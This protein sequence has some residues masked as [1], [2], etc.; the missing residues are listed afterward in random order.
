MRCRSAASRGCRALRGQEALALLACVRALADVDEESLDVE[1]PAVVVAHGDGLVSDPD[2]APVAREHPVL[3]AQRRRGGGSLGD[4][5]GH[6]VAVLGVDELEEEVG[7]GEPFAGRVAE[8]R[9]D[10]RTDVERLAALAERVDVRDGG[11][12]VGQGAVLG[13][14][15]APPGV[16][17]PRLADIRGDQDRS[18]RLAVLVP[19]G[20]DGERDGDLLAALAP[21][22]RRRDVEPLR[23]VDGHEGGRDDVLSAEDR[24]LAADRLVGA[25]AVD[26]LGAPAPADDRP[27]CVDCDDRLRAGFPHGGELP[28]EVRPG[29]RRLASS[30]RQPAGEST[31]R[32]PRG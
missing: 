6:P 15:L 5:V 22:R 13:L 20:R 16:D 23:R 7:L 26:L 29:P 31:D 27:L 24:K 1:R 8:Q 32:E 12:V 9:R 10:L 3:G 17:P 25:V 11:E 14:D 30:R 19:E 4:L 21:V 18:G 28:L 2:D